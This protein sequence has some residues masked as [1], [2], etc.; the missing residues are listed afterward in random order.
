M[1]RVLAV[2]DNPIIRLGLR[3][4]L[5]NSDGVD[6]VRETD[7]PDVALA[8]AR[9]EVDIALL[10]VQMPRVSGLDLLPQLAAHVPVMMLTHDESSETLAEAM[11]AGA[12][13]YLVH[14]SLDP[15]GILEALRMGLRG[16]TVVSGAS[17]TWQQASAQDG[18]PDGGLRSLL[19]ERERDVMDAIARGLTNGEIA[20]SL[21]LTEKTVKNNINRIFSK[22]QVRSRGEAIARW[23]EPG[24]G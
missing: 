2:D 23:R 12:V 24:P 11:S 13:G 8:I 4:M 20:R 9:G 16:T 22:L 5:E 3:V 17:P 14:G 1:I 7:D 19:T 18:E 6:A 21:F 15:E 10:D